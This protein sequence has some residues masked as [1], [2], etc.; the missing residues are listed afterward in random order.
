ML[1][2]IEICKTAKATVVAAGTYILSKVGDGHLLNLGLTLPRSRDG[3]G[4]ISAYLKT[5]FRVITS[6]FWGHTVTA[7][8]TIPWLR[9]I[10][11]RPLLMTFTSPRTPMLLSA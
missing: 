9:T 5:S 8:V 6:P 10:L 7:I 2:I 3:N 1:E 11:R 4:L